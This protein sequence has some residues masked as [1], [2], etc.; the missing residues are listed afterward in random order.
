MEILETWGGEA[1]HRFVGGIAS[2]CRADG[3]ADF[4]TDASPSG[5]IDSEGARANLINGYSPDID[6]G[7][8]LPPPTRD[9]MLNLDGRLG[10]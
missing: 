9:S 8:M 7:N 3:F 4:L 5:F 10:G 2:P 6:T 1:A